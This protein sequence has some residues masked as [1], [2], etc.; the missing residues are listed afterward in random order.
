M[1]KHT[2]EQIRMA[3]DMAARLKW[4][5]V[6]RDRETGLKVCTALLDCG[7]EDKRFLVTGRASS[8]TESKRMAAAMVIELLREHAY[9]T[10]P[11]TPH[12]QTDAPV[13]SPSTSAT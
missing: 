12:T 3:D 5:S 11:R 1:V 6:H 2:I 7:G 10:S 4:H 9:R 13:A 8:V